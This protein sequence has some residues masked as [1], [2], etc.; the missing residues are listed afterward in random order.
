M[1]PA[2]RGVTFSLIKL[3]ALWT[4]VCD[5][6]LPILAKN[7]LPR[8]DFGQLSIPTSCFVS[9]ARAATAFGDVDDVIYIGPPLCENRG[10]RRTFEVSLWPFEAP[11]TVLRTR[12]TRGCHGLW[13][14]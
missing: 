7:A 6:I 5:H 12:G 10:T 1:Q 9:F 8:S 4:H 14:P 3:N 13:M 11:A 2:K